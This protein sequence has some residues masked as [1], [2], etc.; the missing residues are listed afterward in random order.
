MGTKPGIFTFSKPLFTN[1]YVWRLNVQSSPEDVHVVRDTV[2]RVHTPHVHF[3]DH[4]SWL[5][6]KDTFLT[7]FIKV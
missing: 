2:Y 7:D 5:P 1:G 3:V 6:K 4:W